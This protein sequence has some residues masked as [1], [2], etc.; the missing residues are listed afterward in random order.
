LTGRD[1]RKNLKKI[2]DI[3]LLLQ[4]INLLPAA[5]CVPQAVAAAMTADCTASSK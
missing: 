2:N 3:C 4:V 1:R 5:L